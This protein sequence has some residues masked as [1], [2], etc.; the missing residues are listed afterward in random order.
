MTERFQSSQLDTQCINTIRTL[1]MDAI[2]KAN[3]GH[4]G[5]PMGL[6]AAGYILWT[7]LLKHNPKNPQWM[8]RDRFIL[9]G[10]HGSMLLYSLLHL[11]G[12]DVSLDDIKAFRQLGSKTP[13]HP[14]YEVTP[15]VE[16]TTGPLGQGVANAVGM[17][18]AERYLAAQFNQPNCEIVNHHTY[19]FC[20]DGDL[21]EGISNE[22]ASLAG[23]LGLHKLICI[24]DS[25]SISIEGSTQ[26]TFT[27]N[28]AKRFESMNWHVQEVQDGNDIHAIYN[29]LLSAKAELSKPSLIVLKTHIAYGSPNKQDTADAHGAPLGEEEIRLTKTNLGCNPDKSFFVSDEVKSHFQSLD[30]GQELENQWNDLLNTYKQTHP[31]LAN[32]FNQTMSGMLPNGWDKDMPEFLS[33]D[34]PIAT[35]AASGKAL[36]AIAPN[37]PSLVGGSADLAPSNKTFMN[38]FDEFQKGAYH[39]RN[40]RFGVREHAMGAILNGMALHK[41]VRPFGGTFLVFSDYMKPAIRMA[42]L[43]KAPVIY[44]FTHDSLSVGEDGPTH[45][46]V[47]HIAGLRMIPG[48][49]VLRPADAAETVEAWRLAITHTHGPVALLLSRQKLP[50]ID[51]KRFAPISHV[52]QGA[53]ILAD[54]IETPKILLI[55][56]GSEIDLAL[57]VY[58]QLTEKQIP[59]RVINMPSFELFNQQSFDYQ[60]KIF[61][62]EIQKRVIIE[63]ATSWGWHRFAGQHGIIVSMDQFGTSAPGGIVREK[64]GFSTQFVLN[65]CLNL[66]EK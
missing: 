53:Y 36:N 15:G 2:Q 56:T 24:Y 34:S 5:A 60:Q 43:M 50:I 59:A 4:P 26:I 41:G 31:E 58:N 29:A 64:F 40:I 37:L 63:A 30:K 61:P 6:A 42:A 21:M 47:E 17:A 13:G 11:T 44:I 51:R 46:P 19:V 35:R 3:S 54:S 10:G 65:K 1:S 33:T 57:S 27:E 8:D 66:I 45:Q 9:S 12:Y 32:K 52:K 62:Q 16:T 22:A 18:M 20:G 25:N 38:G 39:G 55:A 23:H 7:R 28:V 48:L 49:T 14:E